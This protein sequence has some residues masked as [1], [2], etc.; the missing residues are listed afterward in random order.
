MFEINL[1]PDV[2]SEMLKAQ[3]V[4]NIVLFVCAVVV[5]VAGGVIAIL[6]GIKAGQ[7]ITMSGQDDRLEAMSAKI[8]SFDDLDELLTVQKQLNS[9]NTVS[10]EKVLLSRIFS[11][12]N[13]LLPR[14]GDEIS[15]SELD[16]DIE[17]NL[18]K[19]DAQADARV[20]PLVDYRVLDAFK[21]SMSMMKYD[22]GRYVDDDGNEIPTVCVVEADESG[23]TYSENGNLYAL[24]AKRIE[25]CDPSKEEESSINVREED[26]RAAANA[27]S[28]VK[29]W[30]TPKFDEWYSDKKI[31]DEG[32]VSGIEH[33]ESECTSYALVA[34]RWTSNN[35]C[36]LVPEEITIS[37]SSNARDS[38]GALVL[39]FSAGIKYNPEVLLAKNKHMITVAP[40]GYTNMTDSYIQIEGMFK[41]RADDCAADDESCLNS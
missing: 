5:A 40:S 28:A 20:E 24:W 4:R 6:G 9:L 15:L 29:I 23:M 7:D 26:V 36:N 34:G 13:V 12:V 37:D 41:K 16:V 35:V 22:Y 39:R 27:G 11:V 3:K 17:K 33:F 8:N 2:K 1:V 25:G 19:F 14:N 30:R 38:S 21:K 32:V 31:S 18:I 10:E